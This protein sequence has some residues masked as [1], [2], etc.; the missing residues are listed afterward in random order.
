MAVVCAGAETEVVRP[1][2]RSR[3]QFY[4]TRGCRG[5]AGVL[6]KGGGQGAAGR[7]LLSRRGLLRGDVS[8]QQS[9]TPQQHT[10]DRR[11]RPPTGEGQDFGSNS[12]AEEEPD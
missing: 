12:H 6:I 8:L 10:T 9:T 1:A 2:P 7:D 5:D 3:C 4:A 11:S